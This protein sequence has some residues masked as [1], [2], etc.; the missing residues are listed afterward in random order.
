MG[1]ER[2]YGVIAQ[3]D[4][5]VTPDDWQTFGDPFAPV[6][7]NL[8]IAF[9]NVTILDENSCSACQS[10]VLMFLKRYGSEL[11]EYFPSDKPVSLAL[12]K[13]HTSVPVN[14]LCVGNCTRQFRDLGV[15]APGCPPVASSILRSIQRQRDRAKG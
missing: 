15:Y 12:G 3:G 9:P 14:S 7:D 13:G 4:L 8:S 11:F 2:G 6:P 5:R 1:A 10:T